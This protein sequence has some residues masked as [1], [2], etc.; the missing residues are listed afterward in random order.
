MHTDPRPRF[1]DDRP[2]ILF[3]EDLCDLLGSSKTTIQK[4]L[5]RARLADDWSH[6]PPPMR[7]HDRKP[8]WF[9]ASVIAWLSVTEDQYVKKA[10]PASTA[11]PLRKVAH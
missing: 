4:N 8:R 11:Q 3:I 2:D 6:I 1:L 5:V 7:Q 9:K 10:V